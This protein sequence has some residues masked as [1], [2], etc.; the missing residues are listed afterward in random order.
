MASERRGA[1]PL[2]R[3]TLHSLPPSG[4]NAGLYHPVIMRLPRELATS[5]APALERLREHGPHPYY[6]PPDTMHVSVAGLA[7][8]LSDVGQSLLEGQGPP[9]RTEA[10]TREVRRALYAITSGGP[11][12]HPWT[13]RDLAKTIHG[14]E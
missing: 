5:I 9:L 13:D 8:F 1:A 6:Y 2:R 7:G 11:A 10:S 3:Q 14:E 4:L 12:S